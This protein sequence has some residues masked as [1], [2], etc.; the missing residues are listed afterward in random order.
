VFGVG[1]G[2]DCADRRG[3]HL[4]VALRDSASTL[5]MRCTRQR[6][7]AAPSSTA[8]IADFSPVC[9]SEMTSWVPASPRAFNERRNAVQNAPSSESPTAKPSTSWWPSAATPVAMTTA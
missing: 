1:L 6:C 8:P 4:G 3:G 7:Q 5:R 2:E 9:A